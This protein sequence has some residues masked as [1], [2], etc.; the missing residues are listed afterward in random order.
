MMKPTAKF[1]RYLLSICHRIIPYIFLYDF[2]RLFTFVLSAGL[3]QQILRGF[4]HQFAPTFWTASY[5][6]FL[7]SLYKHRSN[8]RILRQIC[9]L[10]IKEIC[11]RRF[12]QTWLVLI[13]SFSFL[14]T[15]PSRIFTNSK[16]TSREI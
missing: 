2:C 3:C 1:T 5:F 16:P 9:R 4:W 14:E 13:G 10:S 12:S 8:Q 7:P 15:I 6:R 11:R